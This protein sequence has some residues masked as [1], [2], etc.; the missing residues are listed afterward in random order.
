M[1]QLLPWCCVTV[2][3][4]LNVKKHNL[5][6]CTLLTGFHGVGETGY[7]SIS[8]LVNVL[9]AERIG[10]IEV[11]SPPPFI[12]TSNEGI[13]TPFEIYK[14]KNFVLVKLEFSPHRSEEAKF[15]KTLAT[16]TIEEKFKDA[17]LIGGLDSNFKDGKDTFK[18]VPTR[19]YLKKAKLFKASILK[20]DLLVYGPLAIMLGEFEI[21]NFPAVGVLPYA[22]SLAADPG[23]AVIAISNISKAYN[24]KVDVSQLEK[25]A[26]HIEA[27]IEQKLKRTQHSG[28]NMYV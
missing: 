18:I 2:I 17:V 24:V 23:A 5:K 11:D 16:W 7:I 28:Q 1:A 19:A 20:P 25:D 15:T 22:S 10:F 27:E 26:K 3:V 9:K 4:H 8:Y 21:R 12:N 6:N 13:V 14:S